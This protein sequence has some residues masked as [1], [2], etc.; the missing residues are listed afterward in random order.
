MPGVA[1]AGRPRRRDRRRA[2]PRAQRRRQRRRRAFFDDL[3]VP[4]LDRALALEEVHDVAVRV[5][6]DLDLDVARPLDQPLDVERAVA[7][8]GLRLAARRRNRFG[9]RLSASRAIRMPLPPPPADALIRT[10]KPIACAAAAMPRVGL[11]AGRAAGDDRHAGAA[12]SAR[13]A[14]IF[15]PIALDRVG[16]RTDEDQSGGRRRPRANAARSDRNP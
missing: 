4:P 5:G 10:G 12:P 3:L 13:R 7:E 1:V 16:R 11:I 6:E 9:Q 8:R 15:E 14:P 2:H